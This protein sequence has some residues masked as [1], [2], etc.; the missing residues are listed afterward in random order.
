MRKR[1]LTLVPF[2]KLGVYSVLLKEASNNMAKRYSRFFA[3]AMGLTLLLGLLSACGTGTGTTTTGGDV[4]IKIASDLP[5]TGAAASAGKP[6]ENGAHMAIDEANASNFLP[7]YK[8]EFVPKDDVGASSNA[9]PAVG[10]ANIAALIDDAEVVGVVGPFNSAVAKAEMP[11]ANKAP[12]ALISPSNT[13]TCLTQ[14]TEDTGCTGIN[15]WITSVR[16]SGKVTYF[17]IATTDNH[18]GGVGADYSYK[19]L[20]Y[21]TAFVVDD[22][23]VYGVGI[24]NAFIKQFEADGGKVLGH[25]SIKATTDY[26]QELTKV[27]S[28]KPGLIYFAGLDSTGGIPMRK[29]MVGTPGLEKTPFMGGDGLQTSALADAIGATSGGPVYSTVAAVDATKIASAAKFITDYKAK[30]GDLG[31]YSA[32]GYDCAKILLSAIKAAVQGNAKPAKNSSDADGA[33]AFRQ[34][35]ID[36]IA[37]I[38]YNGNTG[39]HSFDQNGDTTNKTVTVYQLGDVAGKAGWNYA[40]SV[41]L[42]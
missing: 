19:T 23:T 17:R 10:A 21:K 42:P 3:L 28:L 15:D 18:Q 30:Y 29:Q 20:G 22:T 32:S 34:A 35:V 39:H 1:E 14:N 31:A 5:V 36:Q 16:P 7:G 27:A 24:A 11:I 38:D 2:P 40:T 6:A 41:T 33:I 37:K 13:N 26:T 12:L 4:I 25:D 8:F 9:E